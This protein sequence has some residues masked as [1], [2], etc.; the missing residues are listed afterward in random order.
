MTIDIDVANLIVQGFIGLVTLG[1]LIVA[2]WQIHQNGKNRRD[3]IKRYQ[4]VRVSTW[5]EGAR[6]LNDC[7]KDNRFIWQ[8]VTLRNESES[9][10]YNV[11]VT[12]VGI[13][14]AGPF[15]KGEENRPDYPCRICIGTLPPGTWHAWLPTNGS[16]MGVRTA[17]EIAFTDSNEIS[18]IRR[19]N[20][21]LEEIASEPATLYNLPL[22][23]S[24]C[25]CK[26]LE[27]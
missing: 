14:G 11:I 20:G 10:V 13:S 15:S 21:R 19:S 27:G 17:P 7:P 3:D 16:G 6:D 8:R 9:P 12:C 25:G 1:A 4:P 24:W 26:K 2:F 18:W 5:Y 22:P 23:L